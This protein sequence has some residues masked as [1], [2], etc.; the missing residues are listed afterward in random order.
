MQ[1]GYTGYL[2]S[3]CRDGYY[4]LDTKCIPCGESGIGI[5]LVWSNCAAWV[6]LPINLLQMY[7]LVAGVMLFLVLV[8]VALFEISKLSLSTCS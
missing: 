8:G 5:F 4:K 1:E 2:C 6:N 3:E 7:L